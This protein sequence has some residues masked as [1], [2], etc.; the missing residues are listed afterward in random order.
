MSCSHCQQLGQLADLNSVVHSCVAN[1]E[2]ACLLT[3]L[4][5]MI[6]A[7]KFPSPVAVDICFKFFDPLMGEIES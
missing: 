5:T 7:H 1:Q 6:I 2:P 4:L 3:Q